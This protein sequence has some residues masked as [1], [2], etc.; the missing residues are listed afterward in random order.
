MHL[1]EH[2]NLSSFEET[3]ISSSVSLLLC[4]K[5]GNLASHVHLSVRV[6]SKLPFS[7]RSTGSWPTPASR[8][9]SWRWW[10]PRARISRRGWTPISWRWSGG[11]H[12]P[13][14]STSGGSTSG[15]STRASPEHRWRSTRG[16]RSA[17]SPGMPWWRRAWPTEWVKQKATL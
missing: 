2:T 11:T 10:S 14:R 4:Q 17:S 12:P 5:Q 8:Q 15:G 1:F 9:S 7:W 13:G 16:S 3:E 6:F